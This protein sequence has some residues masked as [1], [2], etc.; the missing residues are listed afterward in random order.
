MNLLA[1]N[2]KGYQAQSQFKH[3]LKF[4]IRKKI[5]EQKN[6]YQRGSLTIKSEMKNLDVNV[7]SEIM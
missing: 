4:N 5:L 7:I 6:E 2:R 1:I 3:R